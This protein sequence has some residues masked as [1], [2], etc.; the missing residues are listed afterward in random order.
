MD[1]IRSENSQDPVHRQACGSEYFLVG[2]LR[3]ARTSHFFTYSQ[4]VAK[5]MNNAVERST[6][7][8]YPSESEY[9]L[10]SR[11]SYRAYRIAGVTFD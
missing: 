2:V 3:T 4:E 5:G 10:S 11:H 7:N 1:L 6:F 9:G 8:Y